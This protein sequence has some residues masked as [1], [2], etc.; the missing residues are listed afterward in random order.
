ME[1]PTKCPSCRRKKFTKEEVSEV[2]RYA[3]DETERWICD[4]CGLVQK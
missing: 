2:R 1:K 4:Y 3:P